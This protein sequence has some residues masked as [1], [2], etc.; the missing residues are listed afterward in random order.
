MMK[1]VRHNSKGF[2]ALELVVIL[3]VVGLLGFGGWYVWNSK[4]GADKPSSATQPTNGDQ[5][6]PD[7]QEA[8]A[9]GWAT[10]S[11]ASP[12]FSFQHPV[13]WTVAKEESS[14]TYVSITISSPNYKE[15]ETELCTALESGYR[16]T[17]S[18][19]SQFADPDVVSKKL[20]DE[21][22]FVKDARPSKLGTLQAARYSATPG[23]CGYSESTTAY[24]EGYEISV[25]GFLGEELG[26]YEATYDKIVA[27]FKF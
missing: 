1:K 4:K 25:F 15:R 23:E 17:V 5:K 2:G 11:N 20:D 26:I 7:E 8:P 22:P 16:F 9:E 13:H 12:A 10:Y 3:V 21:T 24:H 14:N 6:S 27:S 19:N 18:Y